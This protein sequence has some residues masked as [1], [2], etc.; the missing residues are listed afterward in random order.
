[1]LL[2]RTALPGGRDV[3]MHAHVTFFCSDITLLRMRADV[4]AGNLTGLLLLAS[5]HTT[6][7]RRV[8]RCLPVALVAAA[9]RAAN[10]AA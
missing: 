3:A 9:R 5:L 6:A 8:P 7:L 10:F 1:M 2:P 4:R